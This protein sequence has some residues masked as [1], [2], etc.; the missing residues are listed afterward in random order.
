LNEDHSS[1]EKKK[2]RSLES[3]R[4]KRAESQLQ[5]AV[6]RV[7][8]GQDE[9]FAIHWCTRLILN[10]IASY[11]IRTELCV[12]DLRFAAHQ[13]ERHR[14]AIQ[15]MLQEYLPVCAPPPYQQWMSKEVIEAVEAVAEPKRV[16]LLPSLAELA[17]QGISSFPVDILAPFASRPQTLYLPGNRIPTLPV[18]VTMLTQLQVLDLS[19]DGIT[20]FPALCC[21]LPQLRELKLG[22]NK[23]TQI[24]DGDL[25]DKLAEL[26]ELSLSYNPIK[27]LPESLSNFVSL[28]ALYI[29]NCVLESLPKCLLSNEFK[30]LK[31]LQAHN[32]P[33]TVEK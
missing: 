23:L 8:V 30:D 10:R 2:S 15:Q 16:L 27:C 17:K 25:L 7:D 12:D 5:V 11:I 14:Y 21:E 24:P 19:D 32:N 29:H 3:A 6:K 13:S 28:P 9:L 26:R 1:G 31:I 18:E 33:C 4:N 20:E 22:M